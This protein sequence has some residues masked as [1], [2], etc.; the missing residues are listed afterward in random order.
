MKRILSI[1]ILCLLA[2][3]VFATPNFFTPS[4]ND[5][6]MYYL[7]A[8][9]GHVGTLLTQ[10]SA[11]TESTLLK[12]AFLYF[13]N[14]VIVL[15]CIIILYT[16]VVSTINT[17]HH[18]EM[19]GQKWNSVWIPLR[20]AMGF[21][22]LLPTTSSTLGMKDMAVQGYAVI[23]VFVM[24]VIMQ[25]V[26]AA[27][28]IWNNMVDQVASGNAGISISTS[29]MSDMET[30]T[31]IFQY[32]VCSIGFTESQQLRHYWTMEKGSSNGKISASQ[33]PSYSIG[34]G[35]KSGKTGY[36]KTY[37]DT[38]PYILYQNTDTA[39][40]PN[41]PYTYVWAFGV[42]SPSD[43]SRQSICGYVTMPTGTNRAQSDKPLKDYYDAQN[44]LINQ[45]IGFIPAS[46][47]N[48][49]TSSGTQNTAYGIYGGNWMGIYP[50]NG[51]TLGDP[52]AIGANSGI[53]GT[54]TN[55][56]GSTTTKQLPTLGYLADL[57]MV[58]LDMGSVAVAP[59]G[60]QGVPSTP[61]DTC[62][63]T[64]V[65]DN[66]DPIY[67][68]GD[69]DPCTPDVT[70][71]KAESWIQDQLQQVAQAYQA[72]TLQN[73]QTYQAAEAALKAGQNA[74]PQQPQDGNGLLVLTPPPPTVQAADLTQKELVV[75][76][77]K[78]NGWASA[79]AFFLDMAKALSTS[80]SSLS[81]TPYDY[82]YPGLT[83]QSGIGITSGNTGRRC[84]DARASTDIVGNANQ[85]H[86]G[87]YH[88]YGR[89]SG[90]SLSKVLVA[91][92]N[93]ALQVLGNGMDAGDTDGPTAGS[94]QNCTPLTDSN[95]QIII[96]SSGKPVENCGVYNSAM[97]A[98]PAFATNNFTKPSF[99]K[100][101][102]NP[103]AWYHYVNGMI[104][105]NFA[106]TLQPIMSMGTGGQMVNPLFTLRKAGIRLL[107]TS[108]K[109]YHIGFK[110]MWISG[111]AT[112]AFSGITGI[113][114]AMASAMTWGAA[115]YNAIIGMMMTMGA[116]M[117]YYFP[118]IPYL[119]F[120]F[121]FIQ[122]L[123]LTV[124]AM[125]AAPMLSLGILN[126]E[127][128]HDAFGQSSMGVAILAS[129][130]LRPSLMI[131]GYFAATVMSYV[132][133]L[134]VNGGFFFAANSLLG[135]I[136]DQG[137]AASMFG[138]LIIWGIYVNTLMIV[139]NKSFTLIY[140]LPDHI[141]RWIGINEGHGS[142]IEQMMDRVKG[143]V[144]KGAETAKGAADAQMKARRQ[145]MQ[146][147]AAAADDVKEKAK[148]AAGGAAGAPPG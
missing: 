112:Y 68:D 52:G 39:S 148:Q 51:Q 37:L 129:V 120:T 32:L 74:P 135:G 65:D 99:P 34:I 144:E 109:L 8:I 88:S 125:T 26:G 5:Q 118:L 9:F 35:K 50:S 87:K 143:G 101:V 40:N 127:G 133:V 86:A 108:A 15:G 55:P 141:M 17:S 48:R 58:Y 94:G 21:A 103:L 13:N 137:S 67:T 2:A 131:I 122:W 6:S 10:W 11:P 77:A 41:Q 22:L 42:A 29:S 79:G 96:N 80:T 54:I 111:L 91:E 102:I 106:Q 31:S 70:S 89:G 49:G 57:Y 59:G 93:L 45:M 46:T 85:G 20:S 95:G 90:N 145:T 44:A 142:D 30:A 116:I 25:G 132:T 62:T 82:S 121:A 56:D 47:G 110:Y 16:L 139:L 19:M 28:Y 104:M 114:N 113:A 100:W 105:Y 38:T 75:A 146:D 126:P 66:G 60:D 140:H 71:S 7:A 76:A 53:M 43:W 115:M 24:W 81:A 84:Q 63:A 78:Y 147:Y 61:A 72:A 97:N 83:C 92:E 23:Q 136:G 119:V 14:A 117:A 33:G 4:A 12:Y 73:Y 124:E 64:G 98:N 128:Q 27:D 18:G 1:L 138:T 36:D 107:N 134:I 69:G 3:N 123:I 130:F